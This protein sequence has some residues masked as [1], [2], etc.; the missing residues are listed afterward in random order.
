VF[1]DFHFASLHNPLE[2]LV[3]L[4]R[5]NFSSSFSV[6]LKGGNIE[7]SLAFIED[8]WRDF[9]GSHDF[10]YQFLDER[11][12]Q[13]YQSEKVL[14]SVF[15]FFA[16]ISLLIAALGLFALTSFTVEQRLKEISVRK[17]LGAKVKDLTLLISKEFI[18]LLLIAVVVI[19]PIAYLAIGYW[20][21]GFVY[22]ISI[23]IG[24]F[25]LA[26]LL[27]FIIT[28]VT[29]SYHIVL[30]SRTNPARTLRTE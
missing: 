10:Q 1:K 9:A 12:D 2:P 11:I 26:A 6:K 22:K 3:L 24:S 16:F 20:L 25:L 30:L 18:V 13:Q 23:P 27:A 28:M 5:P 19:S 29:I 8:K 21:E 15:S 4:F 7:E 14:L 17:V